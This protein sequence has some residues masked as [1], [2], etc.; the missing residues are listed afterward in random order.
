MGKCT[1]NPI[2]CNLTKSANLAEARTNVNKAADDWKDYYVKNAND[3]KTLNDKVITAMESLLAVEVYHHGDGSVSQIW[4]GYRGWDWPSAGLTDIAEFTSAVASGDSAAIGW[5]WRWC[6]HKMSLKNSKCGERGGRYNNG[7]SDKPF[8]KTRY[9]PAHGTAWNPDGDNFSDFYTAPARSKTGFTSE[10][11]GVWGEFQYS[12]DAMSSTVWT[13]NCFPSSYGMTSSDVMGDLGDVSPSGTGAKTKQEIALEKVYDR[14]TGQENCWILNHLQQWKYLAASNTDASSRYTGG[15]QYSLFR[16]LYLDCGGMKK[17]PGTIKAGNNMHQHNDG[18]SWAVKDRFKFWTTNTCFMDN[19]DGSY[20]YE[21]RTNATTAGQFDVEVYQWNYPLGG[22]GATAGE[23]RTAGSSVQKFSGTGAGYYVPPKHAARRGGPM[24]AKD[25]GKVSK[26]FVSAR[27]AYDKF[28]EKLEEAKDKAQALYCAKR[29]VIKKYDQEISDLEDEGTP[30]AL[31]EAERLK[32]ERD[33]IEDSTAIELTSD[34]RK[35][36]LYR[37]QCFLLS[38]MHKIS[39]WKQKRLERPAYN[40][41]GK[42][43]LTTDHSMHN[44]LGMWRPKKLP[45][46]PAP[47]ASDELDKTYLDN[48]HASSNASL[49]VDGEPYAFINRLTQSPSQKYLFEAMSQDLSTFM[50]MVRLFKIM[51]KKATGDPMKNVEKEFNFD[52]YATPEDVESLTKNKERR[53]FG[54]GLKSFSIKFDG[55][56]PFAVKKSIKANLKIFAANFTELLRPRPGGYR[57]VDL[58]LKTGGDRSKNWTTDERGEKSTC[59]NTVEVENTALSK[60]NFRLK[61]VV[62]WN[63]ASG[64]L[65]HLSDENIKDAIYDSYV[66]I[67]LTPTVHNF[68]IDEMGRVVMNINYLAYIED[69]FDQEQ[70]SIFTNKEV[71]VPQMLRKLTYKHW[72]AL[73]D[74]EQ[75]TNIKDSYGD[76]VLEEKRKSVSYLIKKLIEKKQIYNIRVDSDQ[77]DEYM[78]NGPFRDPPGSPP[79][80]LRPSNDTFPEDLEASIEAA[81]KR[82]GEKDQGSVAFSLTVTNPNQ[83]YV[84]FFYLSDLIDNILEGIDRSFEELTGA[85]SDVPHL[86]TT[87]D[88]KYGFTTN[89]CDR[90]NKIMELNSFEVNFK[91]YRVV[92]G[93]L[94]IEQFPRAG[95]TRFVNIGDIPVSVKYFVEFL[96]EKLSSKEEGVYLLS[97]FMNDIINGLVR[98]FLNDDTCWDVK[99][100]QRVSLN[101]SAIS[102][103][104]EGKANN[105]M[106]ERR[107]EITNHLVNVKGEWTTKGPGKKPTYNGRLRMAD[108]NIGKYQPLLQVGGQ[109]GKPDGGNPGAER[110]VNYM[111]YSVGRTQPAEYMK[112]NKAFDESRGIFHYVLGRDKGIIKSI[113]LQKTSTPG[114]QEVRFEQSGYDGL[115]QLLVQYDVN[116]ETYLNIKTFPGTYLFVDPRGFDPS[117]NLIPCSDNNLTEY[118]IGGYYM[119]ITSEHTIS[120]ATAPTTKIVAKWVN[121]IGHDDEDA[122]H[123]KCGTVQSIE[124]LNAAG[125]ES[126]ACGTWRAQRKD[127]SGGLGGT[128]MDGVSL[129]APTEY[130]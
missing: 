24:R 22:L 105:I 125:A 49:L 123:T 100:N 76:L 111:I 10:V 68:E 93:P 8:F 95:H 1:A 28:M 53:S 121:K 6:G 75:L 44:K 67:N 57:Y 90:L 38:G 117:S 83:E 101:Q 48:Y 18:S 92:L 60:L 54:V 55:S 63:E 84:S 37:E 16:I 25:H 126:T 115:K 130:L 15:G 65:S 87:Q 39:N 50:P 114:L 79:M 88:G 120:A 30:E 61:A 78:R 74:S 97:R 32:E 52:Q 128:T 113:D 9:G 69:F 85:L 118:G 77:M 91:N 40:R 20:A 36:E 3:L 110:E 45:Y 41:W 66:T 43:T 21:K 7:G 89:R 14:A 33:A 26:E 64:N 127:E 82:Y 56:N 5:Q 86:Y 2:H 98:T 73:C 96:T 12:W 4:G 51:T 109:R 42:Q 72:D 46:E 13:H 19:R 17:W 27:K 94:E 119:I 102:S 108:V 124:E 62:G 29:D 129:E 70:F 31:A 80:S 35:K 103:Y 47:E 11:T 112:G 71:L 122:E 104:K 34:Y 58:A 23:P 59:K 107:D 81:L 99:T 106:G 116:I